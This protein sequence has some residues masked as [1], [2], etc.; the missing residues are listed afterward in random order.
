M[1]ND[2]YALNGELSATS[3]VLGTEIKAYVQTIV[4]A[5]IS[6]GVLTLD[7]SPAGGDVFDVA[8]NANITSIVLQNLSTT[9][10]TTFTIRFIA[11]GTQRT[12]VWPG[13]WHWADNV[14][15]TMTATA[16]KADIV[17][18]LC[19]GTTDLYPGIYTSNA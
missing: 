15:P 18:V 19:F 12:I 7:L 3:K 9:K 11:D 6:A 16:G 5:V 10:A 4:S 1:A 17:T 2:Q 13:A 14:P 8:L